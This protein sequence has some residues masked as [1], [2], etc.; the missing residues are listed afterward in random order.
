MWSAMLGVFTAVLLRIQIFG[1]VMP[2]LWASSFETSIA[3][4]PQCK[5]D[6][7]KLLGQEHKHG[8]SHNICP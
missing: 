6:V 2:C 8:E 7:I 5:K 1:D 4:P 3:T